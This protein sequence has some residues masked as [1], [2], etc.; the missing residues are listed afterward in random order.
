MKLYL[1]IFICLFAAGNLGAQGPWQ[2]TGRTHSELDWFTLETEHYNV[3]YH[4]GIED[5]AERGASIAEQV[6]QPLLDQ[7]DM[8]TI[9][10]I[11]IIFTTQDE[12]MNGY[13]YGFS[14]LWRMNFS[15]SF[16]FM[17]QDPG[18]R[19]RSDHFY[20]QECRDGS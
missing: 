7:L 9:P 1:N 6:W 13:A 4:N 11:D 2:M 20:F 14:R 5:I 17:A 16:C 10:K 19:N 18:F 12:I 3:H 8:D 15:I